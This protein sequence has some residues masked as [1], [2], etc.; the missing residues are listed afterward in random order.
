MFDIDFEFDSIVFFDVIIYRPFR[1]CPTQNQRWTSSKTTKNSKQHRKRRKIAAS[2]TTKNSK[3]TLDIIEND[4]KISVFV[5]CFRR[6]NGTWIFKKSRGFLILFEV[7]N[8]KSNFLLKSTSRQ[9]AKNDRQDTKND[10]KKGH[11][12]A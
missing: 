7:K 12:R 4:E 11:P 2:K 8:P 3:P 6:R 9:D 1:C 10:T 5:C